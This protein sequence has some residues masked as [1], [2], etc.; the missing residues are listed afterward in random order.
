MKEALSGTTTWARQTQL[1]GLI[2]ARYTV[3]RLNS[4]LIIILTSEHM[5][6]LSY[7]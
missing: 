3:D 6:I 4:N 7:Y 2:L 1:M 5:D